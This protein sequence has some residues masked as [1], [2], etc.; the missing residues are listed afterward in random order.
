MYA[1]AV[2]EN[3]VWIATD[4][5]DVLGFVEIRPGEIEKLFVRARSA[6]RRIGSALLGLGVNQVRDTFSGPI[7]ALALLNARTFYERHGFTKVGE[8]AILR[9]PSQIAIAV[10]RMEFQAPSTHDAA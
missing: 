1:K 7:T 10:A 5:H 9:G 4:A 3:R 8:S 2:R 6:R